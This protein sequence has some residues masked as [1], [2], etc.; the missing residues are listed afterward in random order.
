[1]A[2]DAIVTLERLRC[3]R[4]S[5]GTGHSEPFIWPALITINTTNGNVLSSPPVLGHARI[6]ID[7][8][9]RAGQIVVIPNTVNTLRV[10]LDD[11]QNFTIFLSVVLW[12]NDETPDKA[13]KAGYLA[14]VSELRQA[15]IANLLALREAQN[16]PNKMKEVKAIIEKRVNKAVEAAIRGALTTSEKIRI[17]IGTLNLDDV[18]GS[19]TEDLGSPG[20]AA[21]TKPFALDFS[22][23]SGS[24]KYQI[25][26]TMTV[27]PVVVDLCQ[28]QVNAVQAAQATIDT[29]RNQIRGLQDEL[30]D[31][32]PQMKPGIIKMIKELQQQLPAANKALDQ[33]KQALQVCRSQHSNQPVAH[34]SDDVLTP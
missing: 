34:V 3:I 11:P 25:E 2:T 28:P 12:E 9:M 20:V 18:V 1:M 8:D 4:E 13:V 24:E 10:R 7:N 23:K 6:V 26:G 16:D 15:I 5:D 32:A 27:R 17:K 21:M 33:A 22:N 31:A 19:D 29:I 30:R 14:Y